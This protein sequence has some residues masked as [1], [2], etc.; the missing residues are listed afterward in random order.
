MTPE[1][2]K[3]IWLNMRME[4]TRFW[5]SASPRNMRNL[6]CR[7][8]YLR[9]TEKIKDPHSKNILRKIASEEKE[10]LAALSRMYDQKI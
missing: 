10:H 9:F 4:A 1:Q 6:I 8:D 2:L 3:I 5:M 7:A